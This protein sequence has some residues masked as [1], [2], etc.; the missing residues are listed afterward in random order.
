M[1]LLLSA[2]FLVNVCYR[3]NGVGSAGLRE[4]IARAN[5]WWGIVDCVS[6]Y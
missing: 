2:E 3:A 6:G 1:A 4:E 5:A